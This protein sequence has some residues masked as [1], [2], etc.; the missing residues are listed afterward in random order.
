MAEAYG[1]MGAAV[2]A[3]AFREQVLN[4]PTFSF[5]QPIYPV[6]YLRAAGL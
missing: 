3:R 6:A 5:L 1:E 2:E 4:D